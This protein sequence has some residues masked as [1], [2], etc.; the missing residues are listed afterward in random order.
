VS[1]HLEL[2]AIPNVPQLKAAVDLGSIVCQAI[3]ASGTDVCDGDV[4]VVAHKI[5]SKAEGR[6]VKLADVVPGSQALELAASSGKDPRLVELI[7]RESVGVERAVGSHL[8]M[9]HRQG[10]VCANAAVDRSNAGG[11][12][13]VVLLP[14]DSDAS[15]ERLQ[16]FIAQRFGAHVG[17]IIADS[18]GRPFRVGAIGIAVGAAGMPVLARWKGLTDLDGRMLESSE[19]AVA[20]ELAS[21]ATLLMGQGA[22]GR[23]LV[24]IRGYRW[25]GKPSSARELIRP[26]DH[27]LFRH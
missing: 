7:L 3:E 13:Q 21:A 6:V 24:L 15:A 1:T 23:P 10:W 19:E 2:W 12:D 9:E 26:R 16:A 20:D 27:D 11:G 5:V 14:V 8:I 17:V 4:L 22:E 18:H 25:S